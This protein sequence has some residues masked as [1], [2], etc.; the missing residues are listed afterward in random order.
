[1]RFSS[2]LPW[3]TP[4]NRLW[5]ALEARRQAGAEILDL[6]QSNPTHAGFLYPE[7]IREALAAPGVLR[8]E[9]HPAGALEA[10]QAVSDYYAERGIQAPPERILLAS[11]TSEAYAWLFKLLCDPGDQV[12]TPRP[13][14]PL[15]EFLAG[16]EAVRV[17]Q[18]PLVYEGRWRVDWEALRRAITPRT[19]AL[20]VVHPNN[21]TGSLIQAPELDRLAALCA[22]RGLALIS[23]E[24]FSDYPLA[25][26][27]G[28]LATLYRGEGPLTFCLS[29][30]SKLAGLPQMKLAW[31]LVGG[32]APLCR[33]ALERLELIAD[34]YLS[35]G[36]PVQCALPRLMRA[37]GV[38]RRQILERVRENFT[39]LGRRLTPLCPIELLHA[40]AGWYAVLRVPG[41]RSEEEWCLQLLERWGVLVQPGYF[42]DFA[43]EAYLVVSLLAP[44]AVLAAG[45][46]RLMELARG[47]QRED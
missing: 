3:E 24:V 10:R 13:S 32:E 33:Q 36:T 29:G 18:Y 8:Y 15:F 37:G 44:P 40:E 43:E 35:V 5:Q 45:I 38:V 22:E 11:G 16:L 7:E 23:D 39:W 12:L 6:T 9:P 21:P 20:I 17:L 25:D 2:R 31:I 42:Y 30:L 46:E 19:R 41:S 26:M 27:P 28:S 34:T 1:M 47:P 4:A 14:Y